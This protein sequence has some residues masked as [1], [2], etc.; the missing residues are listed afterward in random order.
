MISAVM[1]DFDHTLGFDRHLELDVLTELAKETCPTPPS[2][3]AIAKALALFR[4]GGARLNDALIE[5]FRAWGCP[6]SKLGEIPATFRLAAL[7]EAPRRVTPMKGAETMLRELLARDVPVGIL[8]N[9][10]TEL[11][12]LKADLIGFTGSVVVS[13]EIGF[14][15]PDPRA[16]EVAAARLRMK[17]ETTMYV[18]DEPATDVVGAKAAGMA[19]C[20][21]D[22]E[23][24]PYPKKLVAPDVTIKALVDVVGALAAV[25]QG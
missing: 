10:W 20:W 15:K 6:E 25:T 19:A 3:A 8:T 9:G 18:G 4:S 24:K 5:S 16:F 14:F 13:E 7:Q 11:Q 21:A 1:F 22:L 17:I 12:Y 23:D 2:A